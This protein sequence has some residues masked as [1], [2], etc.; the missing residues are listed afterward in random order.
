MDSGSATMI[1]GLVIIADSYTFA[2]M[3]IK[4]KTFN[5]HAEAKCIQVYDALC[6]YRSIPA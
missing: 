1:I 2:K 6:S 3:C 5:R 4:E